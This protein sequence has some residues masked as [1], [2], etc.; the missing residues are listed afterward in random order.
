MIRMELSFV[1]AA[2]LIML[3]PGC[4]SGSGS[5]DGPYSSYVFISDTDQRIQIYRDGGMEWKNAD[6]FQLN[7]RGDEHT[8]ELRESGD[9]GYRY[10]VLDSGDVDTETIGNEI[11]FR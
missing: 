2:L 8:V 5:S 7:D 3:A 10:V 1:A 6:T 4:D 9:I 11:F